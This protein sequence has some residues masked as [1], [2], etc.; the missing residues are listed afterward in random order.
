MKH[1]RLPPFAPVL[2]SPVPQVPVGLSCALG[3]LHLGQVARVKVPPHL[4]EQAVTD[5]EGEVDG[6]LELPHAEDALVCEE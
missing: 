1:Y 4:M 3:Y 2:Q 6:C 5:I